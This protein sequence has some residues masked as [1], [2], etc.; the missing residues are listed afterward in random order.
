VAS[1]VA[2]R[3][4]PSLRPPLRT[5]EPRKVDRTGMVRFGSG[6][7]AVASELVGSVVEVRAEEG[8]V[9][10]S[11]HGR[12]LVC[13]GLVTPGDVALGPNADRMRRPTRAWGKELLVHSLERAVRFRRFKAAD[14]RAILAA[15]SGV[16]LP[17]RAGGQL[18]L[19]LPTVPEWSLSA[20][21]LEA[22]GTIGAGR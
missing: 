10:I 4:L 9:V 1:L 20:Y 12:E 5:G 22:I 16:P 14:I 6:R 8:E 13:H 15:G 21:A 18:P 17:D 7:C 19:E 11:Q 3:P 2:D